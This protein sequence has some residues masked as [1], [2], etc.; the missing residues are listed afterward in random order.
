MQLLQRVHHG[1]YS[2]VQIH[3]KQID[4]SFSG[5]MDGNNYWHSRSYYLGMHIF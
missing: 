3:K 5:M 2:I 4:Y 1:H